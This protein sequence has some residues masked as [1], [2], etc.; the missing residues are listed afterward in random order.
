MLKKANTLRRFLLPILASELAKI[1][2]GVRETN[3]QLMCRAL[4]NKAKAGDTAA[5]KMIVDLLEATSKNSDRCGF[6]RV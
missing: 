4:A 3:A 2:V 1:E 6:V 5:C